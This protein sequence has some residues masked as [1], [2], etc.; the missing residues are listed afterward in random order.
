[1]PV[2]S[3]LLP[4]KLRPR[5]LTFPLAPTLFALLLLM[6]A[7]PALAGGGWVAPVGSG[8]V[9]VGFS[10]KTADTSWDAFGTTFANSGRF[11]NHDFRYTYLSGEVGVVDR[12]SFAFLIT[13]LEGL[14]GP[15]GHLHR[16]AGWSDAWLGLR[17]GLRQDDWPMSLNLTV[18][19]PALYDQDG[20]YSLELYDKEG[21]PVGLSPEWRGLLKHDVS[22]TWAVSRSLPNGGWWSAETGYT[23]REGAPA[24]QVPLAAEV[25]WGLP[26]YGLRVKGAALVVESLGNDSAREPDD[27]FGSR[28]GFN[29]NDASMGRAA[30]SLLVPVG[31]GGL[32]NL[33]VGYGQWLWGRSAR[34]YEEPFVSISRRF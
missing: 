14:E 7:L 25:G 13:Y 33:E 2:L 27:R 1:M 17:Y 23:W 8:D 11:E 9:Q 3:S 10:R 26:W 16:N 5:R 30:I 29:F 20:P 19:T 12:L 24:D 15:D 32:F 22:L 4:L 6:V 18:R 31:P 28:A 21:N 34:Q